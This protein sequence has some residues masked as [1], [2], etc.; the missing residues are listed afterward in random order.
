MMEKKTSWGRGLGVSLL[1]CGGLASSCVDTDSALV[2]FGRGLDSPNDTV[3]SL[4][5]IM[6]K[7]QA[8]ADRTV[9][10]GELRGDLT[11][12]TEAAETDLKELASFEAGP[13]NR[14]NAPEDY[15]AIIQNCNYFVANADTSL[16]LRGEKVFIREYAAV[17]AFRAWAYLQLATYYGKVPFYTRPLMT[18]EEA[19]PGKLP[20]YDVKQ[21]CD[22]FIADLAPFVETDY[23]LGNAADLSQRFIPVRVLLGDL[24][25]WAGRYREAAEYYHAYLTHPDE[26]RHPEAVMEASWGGANPEFEISSASGPTNPLA[27][28]YMADE[29]YNGLVSYLNDVFESTEDNRYYFQATSSIAMAELSAAQK[30]VKVYN[31]PTTNLP[32]TVYGPEDPDFY[33]QGTLK[34]DLRLWAKV[35]TSKSTGEDGF[36]EDNQNL[37]MMDDNLTRVPFYRLST[38]YLRLAEAYNRAGLPESAFAVLKYGLSELTAERYVSGAERA[39]AGSLL[40][41]NRNNFITRGMQGTVNTKGIHSYGCGETWADNLYAIPALATRED[42]V[43]YVEDLICDEMALEQGFEGC[44]FGDLQRIALRRDDTD[45]L[46]RRVAGRGGK[47]NF[48]EELYGRLSDR[49]NWY[50]PLE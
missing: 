32:D 15:Y 2:D 24:C 4:L 27:Y 29:E 14:Y 6:N 13:D 22:Y 34:G 47:Q 48:D 49:N 8:V 30:Y 35:K 18:E 28:I 39:R 43:L 10:L 42:S 50:L 1:L 19:D 17:K 44:R 16:S 3:Y 46:A 31:D 36:A 9:I 12:V 45:F 21:I 11:A 5:G 33:P 41:W 23:P 40:T 25:L 20:W 7:V 38:V 26:P 37:A